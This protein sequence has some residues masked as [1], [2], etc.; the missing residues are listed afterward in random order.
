[1]IAPITRCKLKADSLEAAT[2]MVEK[3][4]PQIMAL[5]GMHGFV[6]A[7]K[8]DGSGYVISM[9]ESRALAEADA[10]AVSAIWKNFADLMESPPQADTF[11]AQAHWTA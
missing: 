4:K 10:G 3:S 6:N 11:E 7:M 2:G 5:A 9:I 8:D 1:M